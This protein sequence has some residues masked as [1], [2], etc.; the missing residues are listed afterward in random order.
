MNSIIFHS[1]F[2]IFVVQVI[3]VVRIL[4][5][6]FFQFSGCC[7]AFTVFWVLMVFGLLSDLKICCFCFLIFFSG[8]KLGS[9]KTDQNDYYAFSNVPFSVRNVG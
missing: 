9:A 1:C 8:L 3:S 6:F 5:S 7:Y 2:D 4:W